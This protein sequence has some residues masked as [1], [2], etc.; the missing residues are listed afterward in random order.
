MGGTLPCECDNASRQSGS[1]SWSIISQCSGMSCGSILSETKHSLWLPYNHFYQG[2]TA[3]CFA[4]TFEKQ[5]EQLD[6][7]MEMMQENG[8]NIM[9]KILTL[10]DEIFTLRLEEKELFETIDISIQNTTATVV[11]V[12]VDVLRIRDTTDQVTQQLTS[13]SGNMKGI[14]EDTSVI[15]EGMGGVLDNMGKMSNDVLDMR[16]E[17][18]AAKDELTE[19]RGVIYEN[20]EAFKMLLPLLTFV[21]DTNKILL[22]LWGTFS[23]LW[24]SFFYIFRDIYG[25]ELITFLILVFLLWVWLYRLRG[26]LVKLVPIII[27]STFDR[28]SLDIFKHISPYVLITG[29]AVFLIVL[30]VVFRFL[31]IIYFHRHQKYLDK[32][33]EQDYRAFVEGCKL[34]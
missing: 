2:I 4:Y 1:W 3:I 5:Q 33:L 32:M 22:W 31:W 34:T 19:V 28:S 29:C 23:S 18:G 12:G 21:K 17:L 8:E 14:S 9:D 25:G 30:M 27:L 26:P 15:R 10:A 6:K 20:R 11:S 13:I 7:K 24:Y 16:G